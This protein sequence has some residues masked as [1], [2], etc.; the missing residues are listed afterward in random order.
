[1]QCFDMLVRDGSFWPLRMLKFHRS[2]R[3]LLFM[4]LSGIIVD[5]MYLNSD[6][7]LWLFKAVKKYKP[8]PIDAH[9]DETK[10]FNRTNHVCSHSKSCN[11]H[12]LQVCLHFIYAI[13]SNN[14]P[15]QRIYSCR[16]SRRT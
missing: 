11:S 7:V 1:M 15:L 3:T 9:S 12:V 10:P 2:L 16:C 5:S 8:I 6:S 14:I 4:V 13:H